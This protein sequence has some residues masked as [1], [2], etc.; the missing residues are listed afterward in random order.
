MSGL[1][2]NAARST[3]SPMLRWTACFAAANIIK[4]MLGFVVQAGLEFLS[5]PCCT[6]KHTN[7]NL[8][9]DCQLPTEGPQKLSQDLDRNQNYQ[10]CIHAT[11]RIQFT[12]LKIDSMVVD[13][14]VLSSHPSANS[15]CHCCISCAA[16]LDIVGT[17]GDN[18]GSIN[19]STGSCVIAAAAG[20]KVAKHGSRSVSSQCGSAD[21]LEV[22]RATLGNPCFKAPS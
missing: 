8:D 7:M 19:I 9:S 16:V 4:C 12:C 10:K 21:V 2:G 20:A 11:V 15:M 17:G 18:I 13:K 1:Y 6:H 22:W 3:F 5:L 14:I